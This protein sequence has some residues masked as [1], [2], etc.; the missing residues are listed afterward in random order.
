MMRLPRHLRSRSWVL[1]LL[2]VPVLGGCGVDIELTQPDCATGGPVYQVAQSVPTAELVP[3]FQPIPE[4]W[5]VD[6]VRV[7]QDGTVVWFD[8]DRA[9][10]NAAVFH[11]ADSCDT[12]GAIYAPSEIRGADRSDRIEQVTPSFRG[13]RFYEFDGGCMWWEFDFDEDATAGFSIE[14]G[15]RLEA[16]TRESLNDRLRET[17]LDV[18]L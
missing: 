7:D 9:G 18:D 8:S 3:C 6:R 4:G 5:E 15:E 13:Q 17:F 1:A 10:N 2:F 12:E 16:V 11:L 14:L